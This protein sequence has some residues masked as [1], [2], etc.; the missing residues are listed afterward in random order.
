MTT[1][2]LQK[3]L[4]ANRGE[5]ACRVIRACKARGIATVAVYSEADRRAPHVRLA[6]E[7]FCIGPPP[8]RESYLVGDRILEVAR[9]VGADAIHPGYGFLSENA[10][11]RDQ[12]AEAGVLFIGPPSGAMRLMGSKTLA[13]QTMI[14][15]GVPVVPGTADPIGDLD[16]LVRVARDVGYPIMLKA[17]AGGGGKGM[18]IVTDES[19]LVSSF[20]AA[21]REAMSSFADDAVYIEKAIVGPRHIEI[22][23]MADTHGGCV[24][25]GDRECSVQRRHQKVIEESPATR[26]RDDTRRRMGDMA[27]QAARAVGYEGAGTVECLVDADENFYFLEMN[28]RLQ[29]EHCAT[30]EAFGVDLVDA[31]LL[32][33]AGHALPWAQE[34]I[35][36]RRHAIELRVYAEDAYENY[37]PSPGV[38]EIYR[39]PHGPGV[40]VDDGVVEG[41]VVS[42]LYD[43]MVAKLIVSGETR[44]QAIRR[45][46]VALSEFRLEGIHTN[47][48]LLAHVLKQE[49]FA[50]GGYT[51]AILT[52]IE[53]LTRPVP[54]Q[55][56]ADLARVIAALA[57]DD[58]AR[59]RSAT[60]AG[61]TNGASSTGGWS[62][63]AFDGIRRQLGGVG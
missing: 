62:A 52:Q 19:E 21:R 17:A 34:Q 39:P 63:W 13:R 6:D 11:F 24:Y 61:A 42:P 48:P 40:R 28:T 25:V 54:D 22:Q 46:L 59:R 29:V 3:V 43:P 8:S 4:I 56:T 36:A 10:G 23:V 2:L 60:P 45:A 14:A 41:D 49:R 26:L 51:T 9:R 35:T 1:P 33:V 15:A 5:I 30:E 58:G 53:P 27:V 57:A 37:R 44:E 50:A 7:A 20:E 18:R 31:Q 32:V 38:L 16:E 55:E 12:C 47:L